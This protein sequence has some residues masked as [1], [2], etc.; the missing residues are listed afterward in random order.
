MQTMLSHTET[1]RA[2]QLQFLR[3]L[4][5]MNIFIW[6]AEAWNFFCYPAG[7]SGN[8][9]VSFFFVMSGLVTGY[10]HYGRERKPTLRNIGWDMWKRICKIYPLYFLTMMLPV[11]NS[12]FPEWIATGNWE[13]MAPE[14]DQL[15]KN[16][17]LIQ[18][19]FR[20]GHF[21]FNIV[22]WFMSTLLFLNLFNLPVLYVL[23]RLDKRRNRYGIF[24]LSIA[25]V[26]FFAFFYCGLT[27]GLS[28]R[29]WHYVF[30]PARMGEYLAGMIL[31]FGI[32]SFLRTNLPEKIPVSVYT[33]AE[34]GALGLWW[35]YLHWWGTYWTTQSVHWLLP[36]LILLCVFTFGGGLVSRLF[37]WKPLVYL[38]DISFECYLI[39]E[40]IVMRYEIK[41]NWTV[42]SAMDQVVAF[43]YCLMITILAASLFHRTKK[44]RQQVY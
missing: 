28:L 13:E 24:I 4:A 37:H 34:I 11:L 23:N 43:L 31:G 5:F 9:A 19:W 17:L 12:S 29:F 7:N 35:I 26:S 10:A 18:S 40:L 42:V 41:H 38:G 1:A 32:K 22:G 33:V 8:F 16:L 2:D 30:P 3:F 36:N 15:L 39:H 25:V 44:Q 14:L 20:K 6:H 27:R 21:T